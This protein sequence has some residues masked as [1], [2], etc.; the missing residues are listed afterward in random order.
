[1]NSKKHI[2]I[3]SFPLLKSLLVSTSLLSIKFRLFSTVSKTLLDLVPSQ[4]HLSRH[5]HPHAFQP[6]CSS[7]PPTHHAF[8]ASCDSTHTPSSAWNTFPVTL[9]W[10]TPTYHLRSRFILSFTTSYLNASYVSGTTLRA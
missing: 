2:L 4:L 10:K 1:M 7:A 8:A 3:I 5:P 9:I 6:R